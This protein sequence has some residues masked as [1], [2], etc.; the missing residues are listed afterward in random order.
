MTHV[1]YKGGGPAMLAAM[2]GE[3]TLT[4]ETIAE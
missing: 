3:V 2:S 4:I 1:A